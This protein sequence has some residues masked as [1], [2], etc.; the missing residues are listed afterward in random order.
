MSYNM[1]YYII[2]N[3]FNLNFA[4][5][6]LPAHFDIG[7]AT[8]VTTYVGEL[9]A[10]MVMYLG[11]FI[12]LKSL[13]ALTAIGLGYRLLSLWGPFRRVLKIIAFAM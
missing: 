2:L 9:L 11:S 1:F 5:S 7:L 13:F 8:V 6:A 3:L 10:I 12:S 4:Y